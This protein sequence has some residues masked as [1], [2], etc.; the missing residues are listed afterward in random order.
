MAL[1]VGAPGK[2]PYIDPIVMWP[3]HSVPPAG[4]AFHNGDLYVA[5]LRSEALIRIGIVPTGLGYR[6]KSVE[7]LFA[8]NEHDG[9]L[10]RLRDVVSGPDGFLYVLTSN[11]D[12]RGSPKPGDDKILRLMIQ[13]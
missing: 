7:R 10:G 4:I 11:R 6:A 3:D 13:R 9:S 5:T 1:V 8:K 2:A 12:G